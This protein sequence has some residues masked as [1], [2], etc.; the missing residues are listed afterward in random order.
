MMKRQ[1]RFKIHGDWTRW[2]DA[3]EDLSFLR[4]QSEI[5]A[6]ETQELMT[7]EEARNYLKSLD[8]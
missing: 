1:V 3:E 8:H 6:M 5:T 4:N 2:F 7:E